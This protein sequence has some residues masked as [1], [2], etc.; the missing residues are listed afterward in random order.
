[1]Y[2]SCFYKEKNISWISITMIYRNEVPA[3]G[4][5]LGTPSIPFMPGLQAKNT[6]LFFDGKGEEIQRKT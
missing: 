5:R 1:M 3:P 4:S 2:I 6:V